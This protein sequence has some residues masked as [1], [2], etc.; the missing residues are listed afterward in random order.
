MHNVQYYKRQ[1]HWRRVQAVLVSLVVG[2][3]AFEAFR[4]FADPENDAHL[5]EVSRWTLEVKSDLL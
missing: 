1:K 2:D 5:V 4:V 3:G